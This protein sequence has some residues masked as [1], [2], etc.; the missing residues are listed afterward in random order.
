MLENYSRD[1]LF[2]IDEDTLYQFVLAIMHL[3][4]RPRVRVLPRRDRFDR[5]VSVLV[6]VPRDH[7]DS[8]IREQIGAFLSEA[9]RG[10]ISAYTLF[11]P[12]GT[13][14][15]LHVIV[16]R[17]DSGGHGARIRLRGEIPSALRPPPGCVFQTRC[18]RKIGAICET[19]EPGLS[20]AGPGHAIRYHIPP[21]ELMNHGRDGR[22]PAA[23]SALRPGGDEA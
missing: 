5:F 20:E 8:T 12:E 22:S 23:R 17:G 11:F 21:A 14:E 13:L 9:Y 1:E 19:E 7:F 6:Y 15:R 4:E 18:P 2:Q 10:R 16:G 3:D